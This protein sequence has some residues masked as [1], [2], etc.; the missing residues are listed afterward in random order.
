[1]ARNIRLGDGFENSRYDCL[2]RKSPLSTALS[3]RA[4]IISGAGSIDNAEQDLEEMVR[5]TIIERTR[6][7]IES[8]SLGRTDL[9]ESKIKGGS[10]E[11]LTFDNFPTCFSFTFLL[12]RGKKYVNTK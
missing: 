8:V 5:D 12:T 7:E 4:I 9:L 11:I 1:M 6:K 2:G 10:S 3:F